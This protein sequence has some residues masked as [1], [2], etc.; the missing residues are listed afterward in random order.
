[1]RR[2]LE[3]IDASLFLL[4]HNSNS[5]KM[6]SSQKIV[7]LCLISLLSTLMVSAHHGGNQGGGGLGEILV[8]G[9]IAK[10]LS[11]HHQHKHHQSHPIFIP[12]PVHHGHHKK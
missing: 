4:E 1:K 2:S 9:L 8:A 12:M 6:L 5:K 11:E 7:A 10:M 3:G